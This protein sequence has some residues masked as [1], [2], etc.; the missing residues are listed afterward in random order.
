VQQMPICYKIDPVEAG[1]IAKIF[2]SG[3]EGSVNFQFANDTKG[4]IYLAPAQVTFMASGA[5][6]G[7]AEQMQQMMGGQSM[8]SMGPMGAMMAQMANSMPVPVV[9]AFGDLQTGSLNKGLSGNDFVQRTIKN[10]TRQLAPNVLEQDVVAEMNEVMKST[11]QT[12]KRYSETVLRF[13]KLNEQQ[14]YVQAANVN[15]GPDRKFQDKIVMYGNVAKGTVANTNPYAGMM[16]GMSGAQ[17]MPGAGQMPGAGAI[18][19][20]TTGAGGAGQMQQMQQ[21]LDMIKKMFGNSQ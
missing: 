18:F 1:K 15:Y 16:Q 11:G 5:D 10:T 13:T 20:G 14:M 12:R 17:M 8:S 7:A 9:F 3:S 21:S 6:A 2:K 4:G 19:G